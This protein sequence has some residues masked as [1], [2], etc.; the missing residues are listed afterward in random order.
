ML[1]TKEQ[2]EILKCAQNA[3]K[4][5]VIKINAFAGTGKTF[6]LTQVALTLPYKR[7]LYLAFNNSIVKESKKKFPSNVDIYTTHSLAY[8]AIVE[9]DTPIRNNYKTIE[10]SQM[11]NIN[12]E[13]AWGALKALNDFFNSSKKTINTQT[14][15]GHFALRLYKMMENKEISITHSYY[16][17]KYQLLEN[18]V[19]DKYD[20]IL[21]DEAQDT[22]DVTLDIFLNT[23]GVKIL[24]GDTHQAIYSFRGA[25]NAMTKVKANHSLYLSTTFR[26]CPHI[27][28]RA[29]YILKNFKGEKIPIISAST[30]PVKDES[31]A[32][33]SR[34]NA[35]IIEALAEYEDDYKLAKDPRGIFGLPF[36]IH[37]FLNNEPNKISDNYKWL[38]KFKEEIELKDYAETT[39]DIELS[40]SVT[41]AKR[42][43]KGLPYLYGKAMRAFHAR[44]GIVLTTGHVSKGLE[45]DRVEL[46]SD[47]PA[48]DQVFIDNKDEKLNPIEEAN[49][50]YVATTRAKWSIEDKSK[51]NKF[52]EI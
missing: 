28:D 15:A 2:N 36:A 52:F 43:G 39:G 17:K 50:Y 8:R 4:N 9:K 47:F 34:T 30:G 42:Y 27:V 25:K 14:Q 44:S 3:N 48:L 20:Y 21:L 49:L 19:L 7:F 16:L 13:Q 29:N 40:S 6:I 35:K 24:V 51:N 37:S 10:V 18:R 23:R 1:L 41:I 12:F 45:F 31:F 5:E 46:E 38:T 11:L 26:C 33:I 22:N 32:V